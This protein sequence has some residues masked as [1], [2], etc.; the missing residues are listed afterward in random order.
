VKQVLRAGQ[1]A[2]GDVARVGAHVEHEGEFG[3]AGRAVLERVSDEDAFAG[4]GGDGAPA[5][6]DGYTRPGA[7][8]RTR[9]LNLILVDA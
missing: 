6:G 8:D 9:A 5:V 7:E 2:A 4:A 3:I 1:L